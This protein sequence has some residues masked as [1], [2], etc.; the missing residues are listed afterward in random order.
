MLNEGPSV[1]SGDH[2]THNLMQNRIPRNLVHLNKIVYRI[3]MHLNYFS[4]FNAFE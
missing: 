2:I 1:W 4:Q 3:S